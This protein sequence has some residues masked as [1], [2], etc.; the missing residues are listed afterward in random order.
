MRVYIT[1]IHGQLG[2]ALA[3]RFAAGQVTGGD[4]PEVD[5]TRPDSIR[6]AL[7]AAR[8]DVVFHC[9]ALTDVDGCARDP[10]AAQ[11]VNGLGARN[12]A[13]AAEAAGAAL[14]YISTNE[15]FDGAK[16]E[17]YLETDAPHPINPYGRSK[18]AG[19]QFVV[20]ATQRCYIVRT[21]WLYASG[22]RN[23][24]HRIQRRADE[25]GYLRVVS[26]EVASP[27]WAEDLA[28]AIVRLIATGRY[29]VYHLTGAGHCSRYEWA[30]KVMQLT[31]R[32]HVPIEAITRADWPR[33]STPPAFAALANTAAAALGITMRPWEAALA[34]YL[35]TEMMAG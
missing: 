15:V 20:H 35:A 19:E 17:P 31:G 32:G 11:R 10:Q 28:D 13:E 30:K 3:R 25:Q 9:A 5:I 21:A 4:L 22:G 23:F 24:I 34:E 8:P 26:D 18:L 14:V 27:T 7:R 12:V 33:P 1:G 29:G 16:R 6:P 2:A